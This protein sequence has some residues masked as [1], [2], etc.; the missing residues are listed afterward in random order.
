MDYYE[1]LGVP[2]DSDAQTI[3][4]KYR[5]LAREYH[6]DIN[7]EEGAE[8]KFKLINEAYEVLS[9]KQKRT[10][11]DNERKGFT[12]NPFAGN[13]FTG[14]NPFARQQVFR[15]NTDV[16]LQYTLNL[17][18]C[19]KP[20]NDSITYGRLIMCD[21]CNGE[22]MLHAE[23]CNVC[24]GN[25]STTF[26]FSQAGMQFMQTQPCNNCRGKGKV[27]KESCSDC[28]GK[29]L[30]QEIY[31]HDLNLPIG[32][33]N[34]RCV[35]DGLGNIENKSVPPGR[36]II[37][38]APAQTSQFVVR[39]DSCITKL[40]LDPIEAILGGEF[41]IQSIEGNDIIVK[42]P[43]G[44]KEGYREEYKQLG[45]PVN[46]TERGSLFAEVV[47]R[48]PEN[49][50]SAQEQILNEYLKLRNEEN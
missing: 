46:E 25:G 9:D 20:I 39:G 45:I 13:P 16:Y 3:K 4:A 8:D 41:T 21:T 7:K 26:T 19:L 37:D 33:I 30:K 32:A 18:D 12:S 34:K 49:L 44:C 50:T 29:G 35:F 42:I 10:D 24:H 1:I 22:G 2:E 15:P 5:T 11:Y 28:N 48:I 43:K 31:H 23:T 38:V 6:P 47:Y 17:A 36:L 14:F 40:E 27:F